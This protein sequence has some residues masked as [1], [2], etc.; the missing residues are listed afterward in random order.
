MPST[1]IARKNSNDPAIQFNTRFKVNAPKGQRAKRS[2]TRTLALPPPD[3]P[4]QEAVAHRIQTSMAPKTSGLREPPR[5]PV[6]IEAQG[7]N[8]H[9]IMVKDKE[10]GSPEGALPL[11]ESEHS[12][13]ALPPRTPLSRP[14]W[15]I[16]GG[17]GGEEITFSSSA[18]CT[19]TVFNE[20]EHEEQLKR[21]TEQEKQMHTGQTQQKQKEVPPR[22][23]NLSD[24]RISRATKNVLTCETDHV[25]AELQLHQTKNNPKKETETMAC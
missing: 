19:S 12:S 24:Q 9:T 21:T 7:E 6:Y 23:D 16:P 2:P 3:G 20:D 25:S 4:T 18:G 13:P 15:A 11:L 22:V 1:P 17:Q 14:L 8:D 10:Q 5:A